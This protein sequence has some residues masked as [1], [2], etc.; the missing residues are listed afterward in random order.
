VHVAADEA[1]NNQFVALQVAG[2]CI[3]Q[4]S[5][6]VGYQQL[7]RMSMG[8]GLRSD[9]PPLRRTAQQGAGHQWGLHRLLIERLTGFVEL[10]VCS[11]TADHSELQ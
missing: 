5:H 2:C 10:Q 1:R 8:A 9:I 11:G 4:L 7:Q 3:L 6:M